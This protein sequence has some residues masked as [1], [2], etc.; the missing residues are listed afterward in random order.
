MSYRATLLPGVVVC[1]LFVSTSTF[2]YASPHDVSPGMS[3]RDALLVIKRCIVEATHFKE[4]RDTTFKQLRAQDSLEY[5]GITDSTR[6]NALRRFIV[7]NSEIGV[8]SVWGSRHGEPPRPYVIPNA[9]LGDIKKSTT[10]SELASSITKVAGLPFLTYEKSAQIVANCRAFAIPP[11]LT[12]EKDP[13]KPGT[14]EKKDADDPVLDRAMSVELTGNLRTRFIGCLEAEDKGIESAGITDGEGD[15]YPYSVENMRAR[16]EGMI[17]AGRP[18]R[19]LVTLFH[20]EAEVPLSANLAASVIVRN[21][22][23][24]EKRISRLI[25]FPIAVLCKPNTCKPF[26]GPVF[27]SQTLDNLGILAVADRSSALRLF[28]K[29]EDSKPMP[30]PRSIEGVQIGKSTTIREL[31]ERVKEKLEE[32]KASDGGDR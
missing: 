25:S 5:V 4:D 18:Y 12:D 7:R 13:K 8:Q 19:D 21:W 32:A 22:L 14:R 23:L 27:D 1:L 11:P 10:L 29:H 2:G 16:T 30:V 20:D 6:L 15:Y 17:T 26:E 3:I 31:T 24:T 9:A 28:R